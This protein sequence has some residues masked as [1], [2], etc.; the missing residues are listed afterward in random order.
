MLVQLD[1]D[2]RGIYGI[3]KPIKRPMQQPFTRAGFNDRDILLDQKEFG[4]RSAILA[5]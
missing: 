4:V 1:D 3:V 2:S 5:F